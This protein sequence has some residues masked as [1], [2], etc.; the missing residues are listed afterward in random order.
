MQVEDEKNGRAN[1]GAN[2]A[3]GMQTRG[4]KGDSCKGDAR[5]V[6]SSNFSEPACEDYTTAQ[7]QED[8]EFIMDTEELEQ[9]LAK[10]IE[11]EELA[12]LQEDLAH[13]IDTEELEQDLAKII[14]DDEHECEGSQKKV[15][16]EVKIPEDDAKQEDK[17][18]AEE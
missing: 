16:E 18:E 4:D 1:E 7:L 12:Q 11:D 14:E 6:D 13:I 10:S 15:E 3:K 5:V 9:D 2:E 8:L 17:S